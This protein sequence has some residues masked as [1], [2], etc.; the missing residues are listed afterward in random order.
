MTTVEE[1]LNRLEGAHEQSKMVKSLRKSM[2]SGSFLGRLLAAIAVSTL[3]ADIAGIAMAY[4]ACKMPRE[5]QQRPSRSSGDAKATV[6]GLLGRWAARLS[7]N[8]ARYPTT[9]LRTYVVRR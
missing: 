4:Q 1:R 8:D 9:R 2:L 5:Q 3:A 7:A 6:W